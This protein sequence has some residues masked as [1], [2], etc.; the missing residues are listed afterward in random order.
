MLNPGYYTIDLWKNDYFSLTT[1]CSLKF[2]RFASVPLLELFNKKFWM[3]FG[4]IYVYN[5]AP[6]LSC[7]FQLL[8]L[9]QVKSC[10]SKVVSYSPFQTWLPTTPKD[11]QGDKILLESTTLKT[12]TRALLL[13]EK[14]ILLALPYSGFEE[15]WNRSTGNSNQSLNIPIPCS[16]HR[17]E[18]PSNQDLS[19][20][21]SRQLPATKSNLNQSTSL[22]Q[23]SVGTCRLQLP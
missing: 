12:E 11:T 3:R 19:T 1:S 7:T 23:G 6:L 14:F 10:Q 9:C 13:P 8:F 17:K 4:S 2:I 5:Q 15:D 18:G 22:C 21:Q 20:I 16:I